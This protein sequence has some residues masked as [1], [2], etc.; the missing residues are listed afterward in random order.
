MQLQN[1]EGDEEEEM[2]KGR[3]LGRTTINDSGL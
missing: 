1:M 3:L 2:M